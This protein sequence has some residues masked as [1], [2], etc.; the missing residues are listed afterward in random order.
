MR[1]P[2][3]MLMGILSQITICLGKICLKLSLK[4]LYKIVS[5]SQININLNRD[6]ENLNCS[7]YFWFLV[8]PRN[9][10]P[11]NH[12]NNPILTDFFY[13]LPKI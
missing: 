9:M 7:N 5:S 1:H 3:Y 2:R 10:P 6:L 11:E 8:Y 12:L 4:L 13:F